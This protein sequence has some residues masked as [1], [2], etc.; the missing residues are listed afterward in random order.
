MKLNDIIRKIRQAKD[1]TQENLADELGVDKTTIIRYEKDSSV[2]QLAQLEKIAK[3]FGMTIT[4]LLSYQEKGESAFFG[5]NEPEVSY[6]RKRTITVSIELDGK[7]S[8]VDF[9]I[10][11]LK[12]INAA[13]A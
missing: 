9:W 8:T 13:M 4:E 5:V 1:L 11:K 7:K 2:I 6:E 12:K 10:D 3:V